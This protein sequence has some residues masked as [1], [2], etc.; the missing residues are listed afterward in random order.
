MQRDER[1]LQA[2][3]LL[4]TIPPRVPGPCQ[5]FAHSLEAA[6][7]VFLGKTRGPPCSV[8]QGSNFKDCMVQEG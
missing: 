5:N 2:A 1:M 4:G 6:D 8:Q 7:S 3:E